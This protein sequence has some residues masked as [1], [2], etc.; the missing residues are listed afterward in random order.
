MPLGNPRGGVFRQSGALPRNRRSAI[1]CS[2][3]PP[4]RSLAPYLFRFRS[5][6]KKLYKTQNKTRESAARYGA[7]AKCRSHIETAPKTR[8]QRRAIKSA[9]W[10]ARR[11]CAKIRPPRI[12]QGPDCRARIGGPRGRGSHTPT[13][14]PRRITTRSQPLWSHR[15]WPSPLPPVAPSPHPARARARLHWRRTIHPAWRSARPL[16]AR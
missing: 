3:S 12:S 11:I 6:K 15:A 2:R 14:A 1:P 10:R 16:P 9:I 7:Y 4:R 13:P 8:R 5:K